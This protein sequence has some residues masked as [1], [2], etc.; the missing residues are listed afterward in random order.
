MDMGEF[1]KFGMGVKN[2][3]SEGF[4][5]ENEQ[6]KE[7]RDIKDFLYTDEKV[8]SKFE[9]NPRLSLYYVGIGAEPTDDNFAGTRKFLE[10][11]LSRYYFDSITVRA[12]GGKQLIKSCKELENQFE[13]QINIIDIFPLIVNLQQD[14]KNHMLL[15]VTHQKY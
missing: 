10:K 12:I 4:L 8:I 15:L 1:T 6:I 2:F 5:P 3:F 9:N 11:E 7:C 13:V 14:I